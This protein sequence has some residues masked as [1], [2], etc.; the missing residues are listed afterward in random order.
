MNTAC[1][2]EVKMHP[3]YCVEYITAES[4]R[5][6]LIN[7]SGDVRYALELF[8]INKKFYQVFGAALLGQ[9]V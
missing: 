8:K 4:S 2:S 3:H 9:E 1:K 6:A 5:L 7:T